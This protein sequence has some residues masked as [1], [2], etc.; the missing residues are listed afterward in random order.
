MAAG[1]QR[2]AA[3]RRVSGHGPK[4]GAILAQ[5]RKRPHQHFD[6][7]RS[8]NPC[9]LC[10]L[11]LSGHPHCDLPGTCNLDGRDRNA[12]TLGT[13]LRSDSMGHAS[14]S[15]QYR[16]CSTATK[17]LTNERGLSEGLIHLRVRC[18]PSFPAYGLQLLHPGLKR[19]RA[20]G[21]LVNPRCGCHVL[22]P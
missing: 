10:L 6:Q 15:P 18:P 9:T 22:V 21:L 13:H 12:H 16:E 20:D 2:S 5:P 4:R 19:D 8:G 11:V 17:T 1:H 3:Q 14:H 7:G